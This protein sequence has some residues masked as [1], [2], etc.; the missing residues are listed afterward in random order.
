M[1]DTLRISLIQA[2]IAWEGRKANLDACARRLAALKGHT[3]IAVLPET[4]DTGFS[5]NPCLEAG[6]MD[7]ETVS[8]LRAC[9]KDFDMAI[10]GSFIAGSGEGRRFNRGFIITPRGDNCYCDKRH[11][12]GP[13][14]EKDI[15]TA[16]K[17]RPVATYLGWRICLQ[18]CYDLRFP[19]WSRN[20]GGAYD[21]LVYVAN[22]PASRIGAWD[23]LLPARAV[24]NMAYVCGVNRTGVDGGGVVYCGHSAVYSPRGEVVAY[25]GDDGDCVLTASLDGASLDGLRRKFPALEDADRFG[26]L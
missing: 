10:A 1:K 21:L 22:W 8:F 26:F 25:A 4:F 20:T 19:C 11:L 14:G 24:E 23:I 12:F 5:M 16:G 3:D 18:V 6:A 17:T 9:A 7:G 15:F 2:P 13:G